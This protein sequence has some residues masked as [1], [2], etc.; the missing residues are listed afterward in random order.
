[1]HVKEKRRTGKGVRF[2]HAV[3]YL[4]IDP[5]KELILIGNPLYGMQIKTFNDL[6]EYWFGEAILI[7]EV[8]Q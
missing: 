2:S 5:A 1:M 4:A 8:K 7:G 3:A 6:K